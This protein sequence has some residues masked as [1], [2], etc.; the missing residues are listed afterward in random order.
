MEDRKPTL[1]SLDP[2]V[3]MEKVTLDQLGSVELLLNS[4]VLGAP[5]QTVESEVGVTFGRSQPGFSE[6]VLEV[7]TYR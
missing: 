2:V 1:W 5:V 6:V 4:V 3:G 7:G